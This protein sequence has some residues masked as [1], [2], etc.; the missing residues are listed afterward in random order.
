VWYLFAERPGSE[1]KMF[2]DPDR[3]A[4]IAAKRGLEEGGWT[5]TLLDE[6][7]RAKMAHLTAR[8]I[9]AHPDLAV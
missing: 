3:D 1:T 2:T 5:V 8:L 7:E 4:L 9:E 6:A